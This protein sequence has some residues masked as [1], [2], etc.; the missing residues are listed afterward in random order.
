MSVYEI[1]TLG[2]SIVVSIT[3]I[4][5]SVFKNSKAKKYNKLLTLW[6]KVP[7][8][9]NQAEQIFTTPKTGVAKLEFVLSKLQTD[10][11]KLN[12]NISD[13]DLK[14]KIEETLSTP[15]KNTKPEAVI[16]NEY[17]SEV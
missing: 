2:V 14:N 1:I 15:K 16:H 3:T 12:L 9:I 8:Y 6:S 4:I 5:L 17:F 11:V 13:D 10:C 7:V